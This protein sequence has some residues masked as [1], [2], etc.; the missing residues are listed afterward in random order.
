V[1]HA[2]DMREMDTGFC[3]EKVEVRL[4]MFRRRWEN[5][6]KMDDGKAEWG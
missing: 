6:I 1:W 3:C 2:W 5:N 4:V